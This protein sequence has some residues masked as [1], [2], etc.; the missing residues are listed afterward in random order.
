MALSPGEI[1]ALKNALGYG[2]IT[3]LALPYIDVVAAFEVIVQRNLDDYGEQ[4]IR[5]KLSQYKQVEADI[6][7]ARSRYK[8]TE[9][10][11][12]V[13]LNQA[14]HRKLTELRDWLCDRMAETCKIPR[15][16]LRKP[17]STLEVE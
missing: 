14:E 9:I 7:A 4:Y 5:D 17:G 15:A 12:E 13:K 3:I 16:Q 10:P 6:Y 11:G 8:V 2:N 1:A